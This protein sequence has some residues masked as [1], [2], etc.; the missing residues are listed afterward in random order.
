MGVLWLW[1]LPETS[2]NPEVLPKGKAQKTI[3]AKDKVGVLWL[4]VVK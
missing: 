2:E 4:V 1:A 3:E